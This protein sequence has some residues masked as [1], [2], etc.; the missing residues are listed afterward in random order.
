M[1]RVAGGSLTTSP[2]SSGLM[3]IWQPKREVC[4][5]PNARSSMSSSSSLA[6]ASFS[7]QTAS[8]TTWQV[9]QASE[10]SQAPSMSTW[11]RWAIS[12]T[13]SPIGAS[14][15]LREPSFRMNVILGITN[16]SSIS[17]HATF[18]VGDRQPR[19]G[20]ADAAV[21]APLGERLGEGLQRL[22][23]GIDLIPT[24][25]LGRRLQAQPRRVE[26][27]AFLGRQESAILGQ[28]AIEREQAALGLDP[29]LGEQAASH[30]VLGML[31]AVVE[32]VGHVIVA[33]AI[34]RLDV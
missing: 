33:E 19:E 21:H 22:G 12:S 25:A 24:P 27:G 4:V 5:R 6:G 32:H 14:T 20:L 34:G 8:T 17:S 1:L 3:R 18:E 29:R 10:P 7:N 30:V 2:S 11:L 28:R 31:Q 26:L 9:E 23:R 13:D 15:S 16:S